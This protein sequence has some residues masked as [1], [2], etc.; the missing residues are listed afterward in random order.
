[1]LFV[2]AGIAMVFGPMIASG[3]ALHPYDPLDPRFT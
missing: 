2:G 3:L 1:V